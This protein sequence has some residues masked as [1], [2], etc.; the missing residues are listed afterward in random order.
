MVA[1]RTECDYR[2]GMERW[3]PTSCHSRRTKGVVLRNLDIP[4]TITTA[5]PRHGRA[6]LE[7]RMGRASS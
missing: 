4:A 3:N 6:F 1:R 5:I 2:G 7:F